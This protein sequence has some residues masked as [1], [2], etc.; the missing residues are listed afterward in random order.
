MNILS[1]TYSLLHSHGED[2][3]VALTAAL[4]S[5]F[6]KICSANQKSGPSETC[7]AKALFGPVHF[8]K[9]LAGYQERHLWALHPWP[10][11]PNYLFFKQKHFCLCIRHK[12]WESEREHA[13]SFM[14]Q[15]E[16]WEKSVPWVEL[17]SQFLEPSFDLRLV[18]E[19]EKNRSNKIFHSQAFHYYICTVI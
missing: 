15:K 10:L 6:L 1:Y 18:L 4:E 12:F 7:W 9:R 2:P 17:C 11:D 19:V 14:R 3:C 5:K 8:L 13:E 16:W